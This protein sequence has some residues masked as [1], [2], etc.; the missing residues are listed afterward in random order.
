MSRVEYYKSEE[1]RNANQLP[2]SIIIEE[3]GN[4]L[5]ERG[6]EE[7]PILIPARLFVIKDE[8]GQ[9]LKEIYEFESN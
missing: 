7:N 4:V 6:N 2:H 9:V 5:V 8:R 3:R 1:F